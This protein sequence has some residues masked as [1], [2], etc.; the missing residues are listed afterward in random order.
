M[1]VN[2]VLCVVMEAAS[3]NRVQRK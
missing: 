2:G 1:C 3:V